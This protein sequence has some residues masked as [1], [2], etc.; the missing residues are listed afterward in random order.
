MCLYAD[1]IVAGR[2][3]G[4]HFIT[5]TAVFLAG[6]GNVGV[7]EPLE[8]SELA[9]LA[10]QDPWRPA[11]VVVLDTGVQAGVERGVIASGVGHRSP[12]QRRGSAPTGRPVEY[13]PALM[14]APPTLVDRS[15][16]TSLARLAQRLRPGQVIAGTYALEALVA[17]GAVD[18]TW[19]ARDRALDAPL[20]IRVVP[21]D[22]AHAG[23]LLAQYRREVWF[24]RHIEHPALPRALTVGSDAG[25]HFVTMELLGGTPLHDALKARGRLPAGEVARLGVELADVLARLHDHRVVHGA[26]M[27]STVLLDGDG[28]ARLRSIGTAYTLE[29]AARGVQHAL[30]AGRYLAPEQIAG[31]GGDARVDLYALGLVLFELL[32]GRAPFD[33]AS[34]VVASVRRLREDAPDPARFA[35]VP[36]ALAM[37][38][39]RCLARDPAGRFADARALSAALRSKTV[40]AELPPR[41]VGAP[42]QVVVA[43]FESHGSPETEALAALVPEELASA[44]RHTGS[45]RARTGSLAHT[46]L[47]GAAARCWWSTG[48][49]RAPP[50]A[51]W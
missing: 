50:I 38:V 21:D 35:P 15:P 13:P 11:E 18:L 26:L 23:A 10:G 30:G 48:A 43:P 6:Q 34:D 31:A 45:L 4:P 51:R 16:A 27:P 42:A 3:D 25:V 29:E 37:T 33:D 8:V 17:Q 22:A 40:P 12:L 1:T 24:A 19:N 9:G 46:R 49:C 39:R 14:T 28:H 44:L 47:A 5:V 20:S 32:T 36:A 41:D 7:G 2:I